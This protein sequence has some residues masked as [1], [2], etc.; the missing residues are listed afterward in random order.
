MQMFRQFNAGTHD[1]F[2]DKEV[3]KCK[4]KGEHVHVECV[5]GYEG[6]FR[7]LDWKDAKTVKTVKTVKAPKKVVNKKVVAK[8]IKKPKAK[9]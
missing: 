8:K 7:P 3:K 2:E 5:C 1:I 9:Q 4:I 6:T